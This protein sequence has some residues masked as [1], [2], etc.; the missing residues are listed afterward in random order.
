MW[1][2]RW[3][4]P[5]TLSAPRRPAPGRCIRGGHGDATDNCQY[6]ELRATST[7]STVGR[8]WSR[9]SG[10]PTRYQGVVDWWCTTIATGIR[11]AAGPTCREPA[12]VGR[13]PD[14]LDMARSRFTATGL[15]LAWYAVYGNHDNQVKGTVPANQA[16]VETLVGER[17]HITPRPVG[18]PRRLRRLDLGDHSAMV[19]RR[20]A[21]APVRRAGPCRR[22]V[23]RA[24]HLG[25]LPDPWIAARSRIRPTRTLAGAGPGT[26]STTAPSAVSRP[27]P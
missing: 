9:D 6:N 24:E 14:G 12:G 25:A 16:L 3:C 10:D 5:I 26:P 1:S 18:R 23:A 8:W 19:A 11:T 21:R 20:S 2:R 13:V 4:K 15:R 27:T 17:K 22:P 7:C